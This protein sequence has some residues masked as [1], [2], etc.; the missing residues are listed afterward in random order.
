ML[1]SHPLALTILLQ[2]LKTFLRTYQSFLKESISSKF[3]LLPLN[4][5][6]LFHFLRLCTW[7]H[8]FPLELTE[9]FPPS[10]LKMSMCLFLW[11]FSFLLFR[12]KNSRLEGQLPQGCRIPALPVLGHRDP[13]LWIAWCLFHWMQPF[14]PTCMTIISVNSQMRFLGSFSNGCCPVSAASPVPK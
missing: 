3:F 5:E 9:A 10:C 4:P 12:S 6:W 7:L 1:L 13:H 14:L 11:C 8:V 2:V